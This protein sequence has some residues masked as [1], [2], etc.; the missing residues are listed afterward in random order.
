MTKDNIA[1]KYTTDS[2]ETVM[3]NISEGQPEACLPGELVLS[4]QSSTARLAA[5][6]A[7]GTG[8]RVMGV[9]SN[10]NKGSVTVSSLGEGPTSILLNA[11]SVTESNLASNSVSN[12]KIATPL[13]ITKGGTGQ[14]TENAALNAFLP[15]QAGN[16]NK[17]LVSNGTNASWVRDTLSIDQLNDVNT[18]SAT[19]FKDQVLKWDSSTLQWRQNETITTFSDQLVTN[20]AP[21][22][23]GQIGT[24]AEYF[25]VCQSPNKWSRTALQTWNESIVR[26]PVTSNIAFTYEPNVIRTDPYY[27][28]VSLLLHM[29]GTNGSLTFTDSSINAF[30]IGRAGG[31]QI[32]T[33]QSKFGGASGLFDG[34]GDR[35]EIAYSAAL[36]LVGSSFTVEG[37]I[38][39]TAFKASGVRI[40]AAGG[41]TVGWNGTTGIHLLIQL[42]ANNG[43][44][45]LQW[46]NGS[47]AVAAQTSAAVTLSTWSHIAVSVSG[48]NVYIAVNGVVQLFT[49]ATL[50]RPSTNPVTNLATIYGEGGAVG[51]AFAG[52]M[53]EFRV[54]KGVAR[55]TSNFT[56]STAA[57]PELG[58]TP[59]PNFNNVSLLLHA[60][61]NNGDTFT[62]D[63]SPNC[64][65]V[66]FVPSASISTAQSKF[67]GS[68]IS[69]PTTASFVTVGTTGSQFSFGAGNFTIEFWGYFT[70]SAN[71][72]ARW[73]TFSGTTGGYGELTIRQES[74]NQYSFFFYINGVLNGPYLGGT[75]IRNAWTHIA[76]VRNGNIWQLHADGTVVNGRV[77]GALTLQSFSQ[78]T[79]GGF[80]G[81][82]GTGFYDEVR[83]TKG[84][85]RYTTS[86]TP[87]TAPYPNFS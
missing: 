5:V 18:S 8:A 10:G 13:V 1:V 9:L 49:S 71:Q 7:T 72:Y 66:T 45:Q 36:D 67:G 52:Y 12:E 25:Y 20:Q 78:V 37:W 46:W 24:G 32:S 28:N 47:T 15:S 51:T 81:E 35:L 31:A 55:Y 68:S 21:G 4:A 14:S 62:K 63:Y 75:V 38:Y 53:D 39:P 34:T 22:R 17:L 74:N 70:H 60:E 61:G 43:N 27:A 11:N 58:Y 23:E 50:V 56:P 19:R 76:F 44:V 54:T 29:D 73:I 69:L 77:L 59:D 48:T 84:V 87:P 33:A 16:S 40:Y 42:G 65:N 83:I 80:S 30:A 26:A 2:L 86:F 82:H 6:D 79:L 57:W 85:A 41:G 3:S 64:F